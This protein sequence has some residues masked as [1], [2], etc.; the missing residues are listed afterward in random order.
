MDWLRSQ[1]NLP[2][3]LK[4]VQTKEDAKLAID[5]D[6]EG[7]I[8]SNHGGRQLDSSVATIDS[9]PEVI[10]AVNDR[11]EVLIDS[12][13]RRGSDILKALALGAK[14]VLIGRPYIWG[15]AVDGETGVKHVL[16]LLRDEL[17]L[18]MALT[19]CSSIR[20]ITRN[21]LRT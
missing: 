5:H 3:L 16:E 2:L 14:A 18:A 17:R 9:L 8:V 7:I 21:I 6:I 12:G 4:G 1:S 11:A 20:N 10:E 13:I 19:G 15:L